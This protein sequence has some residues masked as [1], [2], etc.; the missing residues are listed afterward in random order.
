MGFQW[1]LTYF[2]R[3]THKWLVTT[4]FNEG[5]L[6]LLPTTVT[7]SQ[8]TVLHKANNIHC[9]D[10]VAHLFLVNFALFVC[11]FVFSAVSYTCNIRRGFQACGFCLLL[12]YIYFSNL[13]SRKL[14]AILCLIYFIYSRNRKLSR[15]G[16]IWKIDSLYYSSISS[17]HLE[18]YI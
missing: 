10:N 2:S 7:F 11:L 3:A 5:W 14:W 4:V 13:Y 1:W 17:S 16:Q 12:M 18:I 6:L 8:P 15:Q 9:Q